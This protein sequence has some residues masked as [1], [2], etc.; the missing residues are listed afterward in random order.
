MARSA[1][2]IADDDAGDQQPGLL[3]RL[4]WSHRDAVGFIV[5]VFAIA[6]ILFNVLFRQA[7]PHPAPIV[8]S[9]VV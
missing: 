7:G 8:K 6:M 4:G 5:G 2:A 3:Q 9:G 1:A